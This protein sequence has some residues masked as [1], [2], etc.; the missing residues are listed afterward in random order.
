MDTDSPNCFSTKPS[1]SSNFLFAQVTKCSSVFCW[2]TRPRRRKPNHN[3]ERKLAPRLFLQQ[4]AR[5]YCH[6]PHFPPHNHPAQPECTWLQPQPVLLNLRI[7]TGPASAE[8]PCQTPAAA[9]VMKVKPAALCNLENPRRKN[10]LIMCNT[11]AS[12]RR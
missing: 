8:C 1:R 3:S 9:S 4:Q 2:N 11:R 7:G 12:L 5:I 10:K 6:S